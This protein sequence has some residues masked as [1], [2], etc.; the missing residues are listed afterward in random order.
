MHVFGFSARPRTAAAE[1]P[2]LP[3]AVVKERT[4]RAL[5]AAEA[6]A[7]AAR[8]AAVGRP[9]EVLVEERRGGLWKGY[10]SEYVRYYLEGE[11]APGALVAAVATEEYEDGVK[12][13]IT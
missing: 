7:R 2:P 11:A 3:A 6:A 8:L 12:G 5:A 1:L 4:G 10:S 9:A 13:S